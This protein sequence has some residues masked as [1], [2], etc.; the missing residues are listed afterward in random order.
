MTLDAVDGNGV[1]KGI[2]LDVTGLPEET[3]VDSA[4]LTTIRAPS[5]RTWLTKAMIPVGRKCRFVLKFGEEMSRR[6]HSP[7]IQRRL[8]FL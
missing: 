7:T 6:Y 8:L 1:D 5:A 4:C 3:G 2:V